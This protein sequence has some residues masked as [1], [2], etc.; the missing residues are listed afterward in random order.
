M[1]EETEQPRWRETLHDGSRVLIRPIRPDDIARHDAFIR[2]LSPYSKH[3]LFLG[4]IAT[5]SENALR[6][7]CDPDHAH[8][9]A[10]VAIA[11]A[12]EQEQQIGVCRYASA[13]PANGAEISVAVADAWQHKGLGT[14]LL[15]HLIDYAR[16]HGIRR[17]F[18]MDTASNERMRNLARHLG[19]SERPDPADLH[20]VIYLLELDGVHSDGA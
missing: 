1:S 19:F 17:L 13:D 2:E 18:S 7:M 14:L 11:A 4:G 15:E 20:Q 12:G 5:L 16:A 10:Y 9:M 6:R 8:D 3:L